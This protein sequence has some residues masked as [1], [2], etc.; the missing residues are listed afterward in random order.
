M[1][2]SP[3]PDAPWVRHESA[4]PHLRL[5]SRRGRDHVGRQRADRPGIPLSGQPCGADG[6]PGG[7]GSPGGTDG[8]P[9]LD[10]SFG[11]EP[12]GKSATQRSGS[13]RGASASAD[14]THPLS[15]SSG[16]AVPCAR[17]SA[18]GLS[19]R[20]VSRRLVLHPQPGRLLPALHPGSRALRLDQSVRSGHV[21]RPARKQ[22]QQRLLPPPRAPRARRRI[23]RDVAVAGRRGVLV[24]DLDRQRRGDPDHAD[25]HAEPGDRRAP[26]HQPG[27]R[28]RQRHRQADPDRR[29]RQLRA[30]ALDQPPG[31]PVL[32]A[33]HAREPDQRQ[34]DRVPRAVDPRAQ[35]GRPPA[36]RH[37]RHVLGRVAR[38]P[39]V[40]RSG[41]PERRRAEPRQ[42]RHPLRGLGSRRS[43]ALRDV[44]DLVDEVGADRF[45]GAS[46]LCGIPRGSATTCRASRPR[47][48]SS[49]GNRPTRTRLAG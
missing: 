5:A 20:L 9:G 37:R 3:R 23:L 49:S 30:A 2:E 29:L 43:A 1:R 10:Q 24:V 21:E 4:R 22:H 48:A 33:L 28:R 44:D 18:G 40:L 27:E 16:L 45:L 13:R 7:H 36:A 31:R 42:R 26:L 32:P 38:P 12:L 25:L 6:S 11:L 34:H 46:E 19:A 35:L 47:T 8:S 14:R 39:L 41:V 15:G 17:G